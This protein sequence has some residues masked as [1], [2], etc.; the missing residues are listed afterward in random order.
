MNLKWQLKSFVEL[1]TTELY[2]LLNLRNLVFVVEQDCVYLDTDDK[3]QKAM[4]LFAKNHKG[5]I[6]AYAR[7]FD[8]NLYFEDFTAIGRIV[9][10]PNYRKKGYGI[11]L[12]GKAIAYSEKSFGKHPIKI[13]AQKY[14]ARFYSSLGFKEVG[15]DYLE[16]GIPHCLMVL[17]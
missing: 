8:I 15:N 16:D 1:D 7:L 13:S 10:H 11:Q 12:V 9:T 17:D 2:E 14:L 3:D 4:H 6:V 5:N